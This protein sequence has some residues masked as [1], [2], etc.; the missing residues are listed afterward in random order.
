VL[1]PCGAGRTGVGSNSAFAT[2]RRLSGAG[3]TLG[4]AGEEAASAT[5]E[6][7]EGRTGFGGGL[8]RVGAGLTLGRGST[9]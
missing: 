1:V 2:G 6:G 9:S 3:C 5:G 4:G 8:L 7:V